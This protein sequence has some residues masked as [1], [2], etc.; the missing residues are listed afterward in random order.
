MGSRLGGYDKGAV[1]RPIQK[2]KEE[3]DLEK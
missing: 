3:G 1:S 2:L